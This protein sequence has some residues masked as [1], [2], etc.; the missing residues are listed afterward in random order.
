[1]SI[2]NCFELPLDIFALLTVIV[3]SCQT[4]INNTHFAKKC[5]RVPFKCSKANISIN[6]DTHLVLSLRNEEENKLMRILFFN[7]QS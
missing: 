1:M 2:G 4:T 7:V 5:V 6:F 3:N